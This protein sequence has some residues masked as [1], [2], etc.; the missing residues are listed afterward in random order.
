MIAVSS[1]DCYL[2]TGEL[3]WWWGAHPQSTGSHM[4]ARWCSLPG[5]QCSSA[6]L[7]RRGLAEGYQ[8]R[9]CPE[10]F[11]LQQ[12]HTRSQHQLLEILIG[13][14]IPLWGILRSA[15]QSQR[16]GALIWDVTA[17]RAESHRF[18]KRL[19]VAQQVLV[20][21]DVLSLAH[22]KYLAWRIIKTIHY[23]CV[24]NLIISK[25]GWENNTQ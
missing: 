19:N 10:W 25:N 2:V 22:D 12:E 17:T 3:V 23:F 1:V 24:Q 18:S 13:P 9:R 14:W 8:S 16:W 5:F 4:G 7:K 6:E 11:C 21:R 20:S 15:V